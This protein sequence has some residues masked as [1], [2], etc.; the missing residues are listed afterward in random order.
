MLATL[1][2]K[3]FLPTYTW[4][5][6]I[7]RPTALV[8][9]MPPTPPLTHRVVRRLVGY[10]HSLLRQFSVYYCAWCGIAYDHW[11]VQLPFGLI[12]KWSDGTR[13][14]EVTTMKVARSAGFPIPLVISYGEHPNVPNAPVSILMTRLPG[15][16]LGTIYE[17]LHEEER[18]S[19]FNEMQ[20]ILGAMRRWRH[21]WGSERICSIVGTTIRSVRV[22]NH[23][24]ESDFNGQLISAA[25]DHS[26]PS[27]DA[28]EQKLACARKMHSMHHSIVF[29]HGDLKHHNIMIHDGHVSGFIDWE[30]TTALGFCPKNFWWHGFISRLG[31]AQYMDEME[32]ERALTSLT[33]DSY[34]W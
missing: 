32:C 22:P 8:S 10:F 25:S 19:I 27:R 4:P 2:P 24:S 26:F 18:Q 9:S 17:Q 21:P 31:G 12:L 34:S 33:A 30:Y 20:T 11:I 6:R 5:H 16:P 23:S 15:N 7:L 14:E 1:I 28:Y 29:T 3:L 13:L